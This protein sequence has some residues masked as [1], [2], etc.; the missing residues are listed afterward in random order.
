MSITPRRLLRQY[1]GFSR[2]ET[3][4]F[5]VLLALLLLCLLL[6]PLLRPRLATYDPAASPRQ[7]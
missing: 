7:G 4:G 5:V 1:F 2:R 3:S 6:P